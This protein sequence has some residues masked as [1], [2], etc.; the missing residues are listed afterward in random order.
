MSSKR[1]EEVEELTRYLIKRRGFS[2]DEALS[3]LA[4]K[5][6]KEWAQ[7]MLGTIRTRKDRLAQLDTTVGI[8]ENA[9][10]IDALEPSVAGPLFRW[11]RDHAPLRTLGDLIEH[12][13]SI[14][15]AVPGIGDMQ[16]Q[17][18]KMALDA[19]GLAFPREPKTR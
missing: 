1:D 5:R 19:R 12:P 13:H 9:R 17:K 4:D 2:R 7:R 16:M 14:I 15:E 18:I 11:G 8:K 10:I 3:F 6:H